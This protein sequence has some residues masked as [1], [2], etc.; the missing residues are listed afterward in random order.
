MV[1]KY[2]GYKYFFGLI[3]ANI[4]M[5]FLEAQQQQLI[6]KP[7]ENNWQN[8]VLN[9]DFADP[10]VIKTNGKF[11]AYATQGTPDG[12]LLN[13][14]V[15]SSTD[16]F[17]W[18]T[19]GDA[20]SQKP[21]WPKSTSSFWAPHVLYDASI[22]KYVL[23]FSS[24]TNDTLLGICIGIAFADLPAGPFIDKGSP[25]ICGEGFVNIDPMAMIDPATKKKLLFRGSGFKPIK[26]QELTNDWKN[27][28]TGTTAL[29][30]VW[31]GKEKDYNIL[32]EGVW[33]DCQAG[34]YYLYYSGD[35]CCG[36]KAHYAVMVA[37]SDNAMGPYQRLG[38]TNK[39]G[40][41]VILQQDTAC[42]APG[43]NSIFKDRK[44]NKWIAYHAISRKNPGNKNG[45][46]RRVMLIKRIIYKNGW[47]VVK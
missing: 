17:N 4:Y 19:E 10:T 36:E 16:M 43:H 6:K 1:L 20:L 46:S 26:V 2:L 5:Q 40:S 31:P 29:N 39:T 23:F 9:R 11:Y 35:N 41:S 45:S 47:P 18:K 27:F 38:E 44:G 32:L 28:R 30:L 12:K 8:P 33:V 24:A 42:L 25:L 7:T 15:A 22:K 34:K 14:Q 21:T 37:R 13:I 3:I